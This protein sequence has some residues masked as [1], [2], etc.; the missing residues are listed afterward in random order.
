MPVL[1]R[2]GQRTR[3]SFI[4]AIV[5]H[6]RPLCLGSVDP[7][8]PELRGAVRVIGTE[9]NMRELYWASDMLVLFSLW[10]GLPLSIGPCVVTTDELEPQTMFLV[11]K[12]N[13]DDALLA[14]LDDWLP[15]LLVDKRRLGD[16]SAQGLI[17]ALDARLAQ[18]QVDLPELGRKVGHAGTLDPMATGLLVL[19]VNSSTRLLTFIVG[20][21][22][23]YTATIRLGQSTTTDDAEGEVVDSADAAALAATPDTAITAAVTP[24]TA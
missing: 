19:G 20:L 7:Y 11:V 8:A 2:V 23:E 3:S 10:E 18:A 14:E 5:V 15:P 16:V 24:L 4:G 13:G 12:V 17:G 6:A 9:D 22:K 21:D 1:H